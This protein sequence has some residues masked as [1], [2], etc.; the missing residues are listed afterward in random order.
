MIIESGDYRIAINVD[1]G[2][3]IFD[4]ESATGKTRMCQILDLLESRG[5][6]VKSY[7]YKDYKNGVDLDRFAGSFDLLVVDRY[8]MFRG[9]LG[10]VL[11]CMRD[12]CVVLLDC[13][14]GSVG[15]SKPVDGDAYLELVTKDKMNVEV[16]V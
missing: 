14:S 13:K 15:V 6:R 12:K 5:E 16:F 7:S 4:N 11:D 1:K 8:D 9:A 2:V 10:G 3:Y